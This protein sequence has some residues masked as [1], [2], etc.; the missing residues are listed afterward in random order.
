MRHVHAGSFTAS[1][2][3]DPFGFRGR[4]RDLVIRWNEALN[5]G[6][7]PNKRQYPRAY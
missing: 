1:P 4:A 6:S 7:L 5:N 2:E 3:S